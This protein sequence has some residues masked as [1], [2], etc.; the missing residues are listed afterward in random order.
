MS[1][2]PGIVVGAEGTAAGRAALEWAFREGLMRRRPVTVVHACG[3]PLGREVRAMTAVEGRR[4]S[5]CMLDAAIAEAS[6]AVGGRPEVIEHSL[7]GPAARVLIEQAQGADMLVVGRGH[8]LGVVDA[9]GHSVSAECVRHATCPVV[10]IPG[11]AGGAAVDE[12]YVAE[13]SPA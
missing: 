12:A 8:R 7:H 1:G 5:A 9:I 4:A 13:A 2:Q 6:R 11:A 10:V 3:Q